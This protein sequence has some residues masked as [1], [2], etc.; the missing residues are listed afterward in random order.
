MRCIIFIALAVVVTFTAFHQKDPMAAL[1]QTRVKFNNHAS[2]SYQYTYLWPNPAGIVD[3][4]TAECS[5]TKNKGYFG[6][7][8]VARCKPLY[9]IVFID[10]Q[11]SHV[12]FAGKKVLLFPDDDPKRARRRVLDNI[13]VKYSPL[14][15]MGK[16]WSYAKD[17][18]IQK[19]R[20]SDYRFIERDTIYNGKRIVVELH[21]FI[22]PTSVLPERYEYRSLLEGKRQQT[23]IFLFSNYKLEKEA[24][25]LTNT[26][27]AG[28][29]TEIFGQG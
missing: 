4:A 21:L 29:R 18:M 8:Y 17:T 28:Y 2:I 12:D 7:D 19:T 23:V 22:N 9:D 10:E 25:I 6:Y 14:T 16:A 26:P 3:T 27:P 5:F 24:K 20:L 1:Q 11:L 15:L 13:P